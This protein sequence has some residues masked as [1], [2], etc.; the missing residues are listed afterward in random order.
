MAHT[1]VSL[2]FIK[3]MMKKH[4][5]SVFYI[6]DISGGVLALNEDED[7]KPDEAFELLQEYLNDIT[8]NMVIV[9]IHARAPSRGKKDVKLGGAQLPVFR[10]RVNLNELNGVPATEKTESLSGGLGHLAMYEKFF[11]KIGDLE[12]SILQKQIDDLK[13]E[14]QNKRGSRK[15]DLVEIIMEKGI[16][17]F[18]THQQ[19]QKAAE[20][21]KG[22]QQPI[23]DNVSKQPKK[24]GEGE[25]LMDAVRK[26]A[27]VDTDLLSNI[28]MIAEMAKKNPSGYKNF[29]DTLKG[30]Q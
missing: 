13:A 22:N 18:M 24:N 1:F 30:M 16:E 2:D 19:L 25:R 3:G 15:E 14:N 17:K 11:T 6:E 28:E 20:G 4:D 21:L 29:I 23:A 10:Y 27:T 5:R 8:G 7:M 12:K 26:L 9:R